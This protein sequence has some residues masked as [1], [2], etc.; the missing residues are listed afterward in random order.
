M[1]PCVA[2]RPSL[3]SGLVTPSLASVEMAAVATTVEKS[4]EESAALVATNWLQE[5]ANHWASWWRVRGGRAASVAVP[6]E[7]DPG[8]APYA[9]GWT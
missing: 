4:A 8:P 1:A 7:P 2:P 6:L 9:G 5:S 3:A